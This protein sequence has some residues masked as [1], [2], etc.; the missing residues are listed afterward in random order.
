M[1]FGG[2]DAHGRANI[3][4]FNFLQQAGAFPRDSTTG[5]YRVNVAKFQVGMNALTEKMLMLQGN[6]D[7]DGV[8]A[9][10]QEFGTISAELQRDLARLKT[11]G[12]QVDVVFSFASITAT[13]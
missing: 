5:K 4:A 1:R 10:Q 2:A 3:V 6:G 7:Y 13:P 8:G 9:F 12:I 11:K